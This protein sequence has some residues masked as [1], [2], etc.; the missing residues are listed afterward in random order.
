MIS[1]IPSRPRIYGC[2]PYSARP[3]YT[4]ADHMRWAQALARYLLEAGAFPVIPHLYFTQFLDDTVAEERETGLALGLELLDST[5][6][7]AVLHV[8][9]SA[10]MAQ[11]VAHATA[12]QIPIRWVS[13]GRLGMTDLN[14]PH[15]LAPTLA[16]SLLEALEHGASWGQ[17]AQAQRDITLDQWFR[18]G[19]WLSSRITWDQMV[20]S[21]IA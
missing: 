2:S 6:G 21:G 7:M 18:W 3:P 17:L 13:L 15:D 16:V 1:M 4:V 8:P 14:P 20:S 11:E 19:P 9:L 10:G 5:Q 12:H